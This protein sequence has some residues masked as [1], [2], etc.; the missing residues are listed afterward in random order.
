MGETP[1]PRPAQLPLPGGQQGA[2]VRLHPL[3]CGE[4]T[5]PDAWPHKS[6]SRLA[7][8][9]ALGFRQPRSEW[10]PLPIVAFLVEHPGVGPFLIDTGFH[11]SIGENPKENLGRLLSA[12]SAATVEMDDSYTAPE[13]LRARGIDPS[14]IGL[15]VMTHLHY[16]HAS[17]I[18]QFPGA[19]FVVTEREWSAAHRRGSALRGYVGGHFDHPFDW[20]TLDFHAP[21]V[22]SFATFGRS[23]D[24]FGDGSVIALFTP[25]HTHGHM[26]VLLR[27]SGQEVL[28][29]G[30]QFFERHGPKAVF[31]GRFILGL[32]TWASWLAGATR[33]RWR[34]FAVWNALGGICWATAVGLIAYYLGH[35]AKSAIETFGI[36][37]LIAAVLAIISAY[38]FG[39]RYARHR[40]D[41]GAAGPAAPNRKETEETPER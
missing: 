1:E 32:R 19:T 18:S 5:W 20:R 9:H 11:P 34:S 16:D 10:V 13:R 26:S 21:G 28:V 27:T 31:F 39:R 37:G 25:G 29:I 14:S 12:T 7:K 2:T 41:G 17:G 35:S 36:Y 24:L 33:M 6:D 38:V 15:V 22:T 40:Y 23:L 3:L 8:L 30:E 4:M